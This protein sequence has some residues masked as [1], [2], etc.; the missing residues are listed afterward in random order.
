MSAMPQTVA[1]A[2]V[3][4]R[5]DVW[6][7][8]ALARL[9]VD[10]LATGYP[11]LDAELP[12]G[13]WPQG[14]LTECLSDQAGI[15]ELSLIMP[16]LVRLSAGDGWLALVAP[17]YVPHAPAWLAAGLALQRLV[18]LYP[19][20]ELAWCVEQLLASGGF[21]AV[22]V[23]PEQHRAN[24]PL[25]RQAHHFAQTVFGSTGGRLPE[26]A[27][28]VNAPMPARDGG[29]SAALA[30]PAGKLAGQRHTRGSTAALD[31]R[32]LRRWQVAAEQRPVF[33]CVWRSTAAAR[34]ASPAA[35]RVSL[36]P[37]AQGLLV[38]ILKRRGMPA[39]RPLTLALPHAPC[40]QHA[41]ARPVFSPT[42]TRSPGLSIVA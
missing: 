40:P 24:A 30:G 21:S 37:A 14:Q 20:R 6:R 1:L 27:M 33:A 9:P 16:T 17:P 36:Q 29:L 13:G 11:E 25:S 10:A 39:A 35:L 12:G 4:A 41:L 19:G 2:D 34:E 23:W 26:G 5:G 28:P 31:A 8:D 18:I 15:G 38:H 3:L 22:L 7:G 32:T 42:A